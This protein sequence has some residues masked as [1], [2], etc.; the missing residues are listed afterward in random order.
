MILV[1]ILS[2]KIQKEKDK[3]LFLRQKWI[4]NKRYNKG[5]NEK[6]R[7][8]KEIAFN[9]LNYTYK[10]GHS[11]TFDFLVKSRGYTIELLRDSVILLRSTISKRY[12]TFFW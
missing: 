2:I 7:L 3:L 8:N 1:F 12:Y 4:F 5:L 11:L 10:S 9:G 6:D